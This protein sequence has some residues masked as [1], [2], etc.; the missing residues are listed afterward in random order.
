LLN[1][2]LPKIR[3]GSRG[4]IAVKK[5]LF[6]NSSDKE[7]FAPNRHR[8]EQP[9][10]FRGTLICPRLIVKSEKNGR[11]LHPFDAFL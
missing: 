3:A 5:I 2:F 1:A 8:R 11:D 7:Y 10:Q 6:E 4:L 9:H